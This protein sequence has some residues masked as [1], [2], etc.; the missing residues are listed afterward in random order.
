MFV[1]RATDEPTIK[2]LPGAAVR[3]AMESW[4]DLFERGAATDATLETVR[5]ALRDRRGEDE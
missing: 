2:P 3:R 5:A 1:R 4:A